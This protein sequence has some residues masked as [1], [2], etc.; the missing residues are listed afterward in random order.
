MSVAP[1]TV[2]KCPRQSSS[3]GGLCTVHSDW[4][5]ITLAR[6]YIPSGNLHTDCLF[7]VR[8]KHAKNM[9]ILSCERI[10]YEHLEE[11]TEKAL[12]DEEANAKPIIMAN[13]IKRAFRRS[14]SDPSYKMCRDRLE[15]EY[16]SMI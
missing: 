7:L 2:N 9:R 10:L 3:Y 6:K 8:N 14:I 11:V 12:R 5:T 4:V 1:C 15:Q 13:R 16:N